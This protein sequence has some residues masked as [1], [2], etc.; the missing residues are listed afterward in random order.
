MT[1]SLQ[2]LIELSNQFVD[3][4]NKS[5]LDAV[6]SFFAEDAEYEDLETDLYQGCR[7]RSFS[8]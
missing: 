5:D 2:Q 8:T 4:F 3:A 7:R 1:Q 6:M